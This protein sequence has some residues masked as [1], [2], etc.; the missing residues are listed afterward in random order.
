MRHCERGSGCSQHY[1]NYDAKVYNSSLPYCIHKHTAQQPLHWQSGACPVH[2]AILVGHRQRKT[3][4]MHRGSYRPYRTALAQLTSST[5][6]KQ[7]VREAA[8]ICSRPIGYSKE[9]LKIH[10][11]VP[12]P[13]FPPLPSP[14][15]LPSLCLPLPFPRPLPSYI[16]FP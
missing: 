14:P 13:P 5:M 12:S 8:T 10:T 6:T 7:A 1:L 9:N 11:G 4:E 16:P 3:A 2:Q 15:V